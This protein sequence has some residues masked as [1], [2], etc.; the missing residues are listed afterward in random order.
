MSL[1]WLQ[2]AGLELLGLRRPLSPSP[3]PSPPLP[4]PPLPVVSCKLA[5]GRR[6][7][8]SVAKEQVL[9]ESKAEATRSL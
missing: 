4:S 1:M 9:Q 7:F 8:H 6:I 3:I 5:S 2:T